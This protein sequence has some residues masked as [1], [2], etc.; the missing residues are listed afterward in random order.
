[1]SAL[2]G[3]MVKLALAAANGTFENVL[4]CVAVVF[5]TWSNAVAPMFADATEHVEK[6]K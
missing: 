6:P 5:V 2:T 1:M 4:V 3:A